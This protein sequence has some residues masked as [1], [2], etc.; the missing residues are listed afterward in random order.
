MFGAVKIV[1]LRVSDQTDGFSHELSVST[2][3]ENSIPTNATKLSIDNQTVKRVSDSLKDKRCKDRI[4][5][6][7]VCYSINVKN[8]FIILSMRTM[9]VDFFI[10]LN[11][12]SNKGMIIIG[13]NY[14]IKHARAKL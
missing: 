12:E 4:L 1:S 13:N 7:N 5:L 3:A 14:V 10:F 8:P 9:T 2:Y 11:Q 6:K